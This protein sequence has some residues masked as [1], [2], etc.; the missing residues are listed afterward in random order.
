M[1]RLIVTLVN[2]NLRYLCTISIS[3]L[4]FANR[5]GPPEAREITEYIKTM[6]DG[7]IARYLVTYNCDKT[8]VSWT[9]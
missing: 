3:D 9:P 6:T 2:K 7:R 8:K 4:N 1:P 5:I